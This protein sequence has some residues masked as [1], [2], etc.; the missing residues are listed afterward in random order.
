M[1]PWVLFA[2]IM[3]V[4][5]IAISVLLACFLREKTLPACTFTQRIDVVIIHKF[6]DPELVKNT[7]ENV[8]SRISFVDKVF[9]VRHETDLLTRLSLAR[10]K[11]FLLVMES[12]MLLTCEM[13]VHDLFA[14]DNVGFVHGRR[15]TPVLVDKMIVLDLMEMSPRP[16]QLLFDFYPDYVIKKK[17]AVESGE[18]FHFIST[19]HHTNLQQRK[20]AIVN[21]LTPHIH[22]S[23]VEKLFLKE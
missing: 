15:G 20:F 9:V 5:V 14:S 3:A 19:M 11:R 21:P 13:G 17:L 1:Q 8:R 4:V 2:V 12:N 18:S 16:S 10:T 22:S 23:V 7:E 6:S